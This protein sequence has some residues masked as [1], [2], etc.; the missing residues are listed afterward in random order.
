MRTSLG[1]V[2]NFI[3]DRNDNLYEVSQEYLF[4]EKGEAVRREE[5]SFSGSKTENREWLEV[6]GIEP[7]QVDIDIANYGKYLVGYL[8]LSD[9]DYSYIHD[10][11]G[12]IEKGEYQ[13]LQEKRYDPELRKL[14]TQR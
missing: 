12:Q 4:D 14:L 3:F 1:E 8:P 7:P 2:A 9:Y 5:I 6:E 13:K 11:L 10:L